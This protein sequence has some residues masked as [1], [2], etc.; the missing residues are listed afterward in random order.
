MNSEWRNIILVGLIAVLS[1]ITTRYLIKSNRRPYKLFLVVGLVYVLCWGLYYI[2]LLIPLGTGY[3]YFSD[4]ILILGGLCLLW[5]IL[6][7]AVYHIFRLVA[8][9]KK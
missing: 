7:V 3:S 4:I 8:S 9:R 5:A 2:L 6:V 1:Y